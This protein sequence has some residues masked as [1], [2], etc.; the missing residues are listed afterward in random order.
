[1]R[2]LNRLI[3]VGVLLFSI[4]ATGAFSKADEPVSAAVE[5]VTITIKN[6]EFSPAEVTVAVGTTVEWVNQGGKHTVEADN[7]SFKSP[8]L[9]A[10]QKYEFKFT[11]AGT[12]AYHCGFHG[13][14]GGGG[15]SGKIIVKR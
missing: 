11:K 14:A 7:K 13:E 2:I 15:M 4:I 9:T 8:E 10:G 6:F 12:Y 1:M 5:K 3:I